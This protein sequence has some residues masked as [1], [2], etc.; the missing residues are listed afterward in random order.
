MGRPPPQQPF[1]AFASAPR[2]ARTPS[3]ETET[4]CAP[5]S[6]APTGRPAMV[7]LSQC[8][9]TAAAV[10]V[11]TPVHVPRPTALW[12]PVRHLRPRRN[13]LARVAR[14]YALVGCST[15]WLPLPETPGVARWCRTTPAPSAEASPSAL[16]SGTR[17]RTRTRQWTHP[18]LPGRKKCTGHAASG[19]VAPCR[20]Q[21]A[22]S[23]D[24]GTP[25]LGPGI[26]AVYYPR[27]SRL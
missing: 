18:P 4:P 15:Q 10:L 22:G 13:P 17:K 23:K 19:S 3:K 5:R 11:P 27:S 24:T 8:S 20:P 9:A 1:Q 25:C 6:G 26:P 14:R 16:R 7:P 2:A 12:G 21:S